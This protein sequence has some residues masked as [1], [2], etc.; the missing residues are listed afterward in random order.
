MSEGAEGDM[1]QTGV[2]SVLSQGECSI[3]EMKTEIKS[4]KIKWKE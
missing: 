3:G 4:T 2:L 1:T